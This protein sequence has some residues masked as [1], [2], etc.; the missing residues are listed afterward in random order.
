MPQFNLTPEILTHTRAKY[1]STPDMSRNKRKAREES[2]AEQAVKDS[3]KPKVKTEPRSESP[4]VVTVSYIH[5]R[6][7]PEFLATFTSYPISSGPSQM[8]DSNSR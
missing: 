8:G 7:V 1:P 5:S 2:P 4:E 3:K 6:D